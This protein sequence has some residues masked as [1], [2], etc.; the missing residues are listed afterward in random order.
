MASIGRDKNGHRRIL[1]VGENGRRN[2]IRLG[3]CTEKQAEAFKIR[4]E[5]L[6][7][8]RITGQQDDEVSRW[9]AGL[10]DHIHTRIAKTGLL[11]PRQ[12]RS[13]SLNSFLQRY[14]A[15]QA[16]RKP[17]T[18]NS[19]EQARRWLVR[20]FGEH[21]PINQITA[22]DAGEFVQ[23]MVGN[24]LAA[25]SS[26]RRK[27]G[28]A[29]QF[30][31]A[32]IREGVYRGS[33]PFEGLPCNVRADKSRQ[34]FIE[35]ETIEKVIDAC[36]NAEWRLMVALA[37]YG[38]LRVNTEPPELRWSEIDWVTG[39][40]RVR[41]PKTEHIDGHGSRIIPIFLELR[42]YLEDAYKL[43]EPGAE[44]VI[45]TYRQKNANLR[46]TFEKIIRR[47][48][49]KPWPKLWHNLRASR[50]TEL[51]R[52]HPEHVVCDWM[53]NSRS[54]AREHYLQVTDADIQRALDKPCNGGQVE[55]GGA[56]QNAAQQP[57]EMARSNP[58]MPTGQSG[59]VPDLRAFAD[60][61]SDLHENQ[62][63]PAGV[64]PATFG[65]VDRRSI[66]LSYERMSM[67]FPA[68]LTNGLLSSTCREMQGFNEIFNPP[69]IRFSSAGAPVVPPEIRIW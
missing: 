69:L 35:R 30:F 54:V 52:R 45:T 48:G 2:T 47:A 11:S 62:M 27:T 50:Q 13:E 26:A 6:I 7:A 16:D 40:M 51:C 25:R 9:V 65:S 39:T 61:C 32:A 19:Y 66:Q 43:A 24:G 31:K 10:P 3:K 41:S 58:Q 4:I 53:G 18:R 33:N 63:R 5:A 8:A 44:F 46:T 67:C 55:D 59:K 68:P 49:V 21:R 23:F 64:E 14:I 22:A 37:R 28:L 56:A 60:T 34:A 1:F 20:C 38:G 36:P 15:N 57:A 12:H 17:N 29:K 42:P